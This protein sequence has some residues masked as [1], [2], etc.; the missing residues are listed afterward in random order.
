MSATA[1]VPSASHVTPQGSPRRTSGGATANFDAKRPSR[2]KSCSRLLR[3][4]LLLSRL[5]ALLLRGR[6]LPRYRGLRLW[7]NARHLGLHSHLRNLAGT[8]KRLPQ[9]GES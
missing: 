3:V 4:R 5:A 8:L 7:A 9:R 6:P 1:S 2:S